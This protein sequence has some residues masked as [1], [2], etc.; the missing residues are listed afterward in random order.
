MYI[1]ISSK[2]MTNEILI[3]S[4]DIDTAFILEFL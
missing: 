4:W 2:R 1:L 3:S